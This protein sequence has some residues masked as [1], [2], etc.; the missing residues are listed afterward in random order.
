MVY[1][2]LALLFVRLI[3]TITLTHVG[4]LSLLY[5]LAFFAHSKLILLVLLEL[6]AMLLMLRIMMWLGE[7]V[8]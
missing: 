4:R 7:L 1:V 3:C 2:Q 6:L 8:I 5:L